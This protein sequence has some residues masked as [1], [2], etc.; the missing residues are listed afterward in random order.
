MEKD[1]SHANIY[2]K[3]AGVAIL[4]TDKTGFKIKVV[5]NNA[6]HFMVIIHQEDFVINI[7][8]R[9]PKYTNQKLTEPNEG[10]NRQLNNNSWRLPQ[11]HIQSWIRHLG[12]RPRKQ[13]T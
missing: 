1:I 13:K 5:T 7:Y 10:R 6:G 12:R 4:I 3:I 2:K 8:N 9:A 11:P